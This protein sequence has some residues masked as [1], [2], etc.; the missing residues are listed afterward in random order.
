M[1]F[2]AGVE[3]AN[4]SNLSSPRMATG[5]CAYK[6]GNSEEAVGLCVHHVVW[7]LVTDRVNRI[8]DTYGVRR[9][10]SSEIER[11]PVSRKSNSSRLTWSI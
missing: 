4:I 3:A 10:T 9:I 11:W 1:G 5:E 2:T 7:E 8:G 6:L